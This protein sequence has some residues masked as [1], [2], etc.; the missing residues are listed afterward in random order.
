MFG[1]TTK[2]NILAGLVVGALA[3]GYREYIHRDQS[4]TGANWKLS[5]STRDI[6]VAGSVK[7]CKE[8]R[9]ANMSTHFIPVEKGGDLTADQIDVVCKCGAERSAD[10]MTEDEWKYM[11]VHKGA[12][13]QR[14]VDNW[15]AI[16][17]QCLSDVRRR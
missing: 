15:V 14:T 10:A 2:Q 7:G 12:P 6:F 1:M 13:S 11:E 8:V 5:Q 4:A 17:E 9:L 16:S 3:I